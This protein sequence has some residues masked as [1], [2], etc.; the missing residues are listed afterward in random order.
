LQ[1]WSERKL[2]SRQIIEK[3]E[4]KGRQLPNVKL[5][6]FQPPAVSVFG[7]AGGFSVRFLD[8]T[9]NNSERLGKWTEKFMDD[10]S[11]RKEL[12]GL[13]TF[14]ASNYPQYALVSLRYRSRYAGQLLHHERIAR[15]K[16]K[17]VYPKLEV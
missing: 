13:F 15:L 14:F 17:S 9:N 3:L 5:E 8:T 10:L 1:N 16:L 4:E 6:F 7:A 2:T 11:K 12:H